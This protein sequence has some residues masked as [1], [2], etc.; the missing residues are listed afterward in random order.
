MFIELVFL[1]VLQPLFFPL[2]PSRDAFLKVYD[3][4][5]E[6]LRSLIMDDLFTHLPKRIKVLK[7]RIFPEA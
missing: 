4:V 7:D 6:P 1:K 3:S 2:D 5:V